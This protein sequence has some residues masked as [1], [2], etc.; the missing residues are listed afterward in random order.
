LSLLTF[1]F[2]AAGVASAPLPNVPVTALDLGRYKGEWHEIAHLPMYFQRKCVGEITARYTLLADGTVEVRNACRNRDGGRDEAVG[3]AR[4]APGPAGA[5]KVRFAP[6]W[7]S[8]VPFVW[9][10]YW[11]LELDPQYRWA[12]VGGPARKY[13]WVLSRTPDMDSGTYAAI[14]ERASR[15]GYPVDKLVRTGTLKP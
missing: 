10:D 14:R 5:L 11:V 9:A 6:A 4:T 13:L 15:R 8:W 3:L 1:I 12:V 7:L 2:A